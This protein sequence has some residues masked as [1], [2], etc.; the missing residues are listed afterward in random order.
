LAGGL[1]IK[2]PVGRP[3]VGEGWQWQT[4]ACCAPLT[5]CQQC[6]GPT[7]QL[8]WC[9]IRASWCTQTHRGL[10]VGSDCLRL[11][12]RWACQQ[13]WSTKSHKQIC[14]QTLTTMR[15]PHS[16]QGAPFLEPWLICCK[17][18][19]GE[20]CKVKVCQALGR[21]QRC[22]WWAGGARPPHGEPEAAEGG[23]ESE[24]LPPP[25]AWVGLRVAAGGK[26][27]SRPSADRSRRQ[28]HGLMYPRLADRARDGGAGGSR[29]SG[30]PGAIPKL[31]ASSNPVQLATGFAR[32][33]QASCRNFP[34]Q[35]KYTPQRSQAHG[36]A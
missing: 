11:G 32:G 6:L 1:H 28:V 23:E 30:R 20:A 10:S 15:L 7:L 26:E 31:T 9:R 33:T 35:K 8:L 24:G 16:P 22:S 29:M 27:P 34:Q 14:W 12:G 4:V 17:T 2:F 21:L 13:R 25:G 18:R 3:M 19:P 36:F 5:S